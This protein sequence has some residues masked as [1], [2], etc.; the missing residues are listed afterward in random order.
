MYVVDP[1]KMQ[2]DKRVNTVLV[3]PSLCAF[4]F[5]V[6]VKRRRTLGVGTLRERLEWD[7]DGG[8]R[9]LWLAYSM[10]SLSLPQ[11]S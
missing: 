7:D 5:C 1:L 11:S 6:H 9:L 8:G 4:C 3:Q 10:Q 2:N